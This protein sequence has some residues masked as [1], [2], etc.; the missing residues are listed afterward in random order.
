MSCIAGPWEMS[1][2]DPRTKQQ[3]KGLNDDQHHFEVY[4]RYMLYDTIT[5]LQIYG[6]IDIKNCSGPYSKDPGTKLWVAVKGVSLRYD[7]DDIPNIVQS[8]NYCSL[9]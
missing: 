9:I 5:I 4:L 1:P 2:K 7:T 3:C 8:S 6:T